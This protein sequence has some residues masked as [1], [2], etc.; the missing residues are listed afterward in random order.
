[1]NRAV[2]AMLEE[3]VAD[4]PRAP[5]V[6]LEEALERARAI[7]ESAPEEGA[8]FE[9]LLG[10][11]AGGATKA[12]NTAAPGY[13]AYI[14]GGGL[15]AAALAEWLAAA[16]NRYVGVWNAAPVFAQIEATAV[17]WLADLFGYPDQARGIL[18]SGGSLANFSAIV[19]ARQTL[20]GEEPADG[21]VYVTD[22][23]H[24]SVVKSAALA[25]LPRRSVRAVPTDS[26]LRM[27]P[28][29]LTE[30]VHHD[31]RAGR[32]P[33]LVV[34][35]AGTTNTGAVD[36]LDELVP[37]SQEEQ[38][39]LH[40]DGAYGGAFQMTERGRAL[41]RGIEEADSV[42]LDP[43]KGM[44]LPYGTGALLV[45]DGARLRQAHTV[46]A[47]YLQ[48]L[49][50]EEEI[51]N[52]TD[53]SPEL[54]RGFRG[55]SVWLPVK[56][57]GLSAFRAALDEKLDLTR[58]VYDELRA[59]PGLAVP[60]EPQLT[61]V[62]FRLDPPGPDPDAAGAALLDRINASGRVFLSSTKVRGEHLVRV[63]I[64]SHRTHRDRIE[65]AVDIIRAAAR[66]L[67][68]A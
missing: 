24:A 26:R 51:P 34:A 10:I 31:R 61:V 66:T 43:H 16:V 62:A 3:F 56:L 7:R 18:T 25:G 58:F 33:F 2:A 35:S 60:W 42:T 63:C 29:A 19:T 67:T 55:L 28:G 36:P 32:R 22:Q 41:F 5:A 4:L 44:F 1:M 11:V 38:L 50:A 17:R 53:Y 49:G 46:E 54:S 52:F 9:E 39:W 12:F 23:I 15:Y 13:L 37:V 68:A 65:E 59:T 47:D 27:D 8:P 45:R 40:V 6:D 57:H 14:P 48:D 20:L 64:V 21:V 30:A